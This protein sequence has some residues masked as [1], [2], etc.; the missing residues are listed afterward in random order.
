VRTIYYWGNPQEFAAARTLAA[1]DGVEGIRGITRDASVFTGEIEPY[2]KAV[3][4][5]GVHPTWA[6]RIEHAYSAAGVPVERRAVELPAVETPEQAKARADIAAAEKIEAQRIN[7]NFRRMPTSQ[8]RRL[9]HERGAD[10]SH[11]RDRMQII[12]AIQA[13]EQKT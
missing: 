2:Q 8:L 7:K 9:A 4:L 1:G 12:A 3:I 13:R 5:A 10:I 11:A 6:K